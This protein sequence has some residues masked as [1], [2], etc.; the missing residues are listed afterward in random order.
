LPR[1]FEKLTLEAFWFHPSILLLLK[2]NWCVVAGRFLKVRVFLAFP[3]NANVCAQHEV[4]KAHYMTTSDEAEFRITESR[5]IWTVLCMKVQFL[6]NRDDSLCP[7]WRPHC[8]AGYINSLNLLC[9]LYAAYKYT[10]CKSEGFFQM[11]WSM[12]HMY[13]SPALDG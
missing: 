5:L 6:H 10:V 11:R 3:V 13:L 8:Y 2:R 1:F 12:Y 9:E 7:L 4:V